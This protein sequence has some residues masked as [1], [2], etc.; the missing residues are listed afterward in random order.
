MIE[1]I[2]G[3]FLSFLKLCVLLV[4]SPLLKNRC[5]SGSASKV[6]VCTRQG[7][8]PARHSSR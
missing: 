6:T 4:G 8:Q 7:D 5:L 3:F 2:G 1:G